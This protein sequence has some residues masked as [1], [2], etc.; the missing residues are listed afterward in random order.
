VRQ[1]PRV[2]VL[3][4][5]NARYLRADDLPEPPSFACVDVSFIS[6]TKVLPAVIQ[7]LARSA[8]LVTL[9]KPQFEAGRDEVGKGGVIR[10]PAVRQAV[11]DKI[12]AWGT[13]A[14]LKWIGVCESPIKGPAG[15]V[16]FLACWKK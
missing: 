7:V 13:D 9:I 5:T 2:T 8:D 4:E 6:L 3:D 10:D 16:E 14:G 15:N 12:R 11:V 1:N